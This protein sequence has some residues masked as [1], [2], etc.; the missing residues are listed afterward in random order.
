MQTKPNLKKA[1]QKQIKE[2]GTLTMQHFYF[3]LFI[4]LFFF[5]QLQ[6]S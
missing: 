5:Y 6:Q 1:K 3:Y 2:L 4:Y